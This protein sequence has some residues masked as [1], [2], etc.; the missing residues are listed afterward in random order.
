MGNTDNFL[1]TGFSSSGKREIL[2]WDIRSE[3]MVQQI[4]V[5]T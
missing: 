5:D 2:L 3:K 4:D 1:T